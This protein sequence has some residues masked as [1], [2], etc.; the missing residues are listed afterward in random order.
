MLRGVTLFVVAFAGVAAA[1]P[2]KSS[3]LVDITTVITDAVIDI[4]YAT[5]DNFTG[6]VLYPR[7][8][9]KLR[10]A[11]AQR[12]ARAATLLR[13]QDRRLLIWDCYRPTSIQAVLWNKVPDPRYVANPKVG[14]KHNRGAAVDLAVVDRDGKPLTLPT[15]FD[16]FTKAA[17]RNRALVGTRGTEARRLAKAMR[18]AGFA[19]MP[20]EWWHFDAPDSASYKLSDEPL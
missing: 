12:L 19:G 15:R 6:D 17:H 5:K 14:S 18:T 20:T 9:C 4:R 2:E 7:A 8:V 1:E 10:R 13:A 3:D 11:V 16:E